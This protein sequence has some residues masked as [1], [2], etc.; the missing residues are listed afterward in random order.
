MISAN[1]IPTLP[2]PSGF[3]PG[4]CVVEDGL[5]ATPVTSLPITIQGSETNWSLQAFRSDDGEEALVLEAPERP[6]RSTAV[7]VVRV[8]SGC[9]TGD[10]FHSLRCDCQ[11]QLARSVEILAASPRG[12]L[13]YLP[14]HEGR[15][16]GLFRKVWAYALQDRGLDTIDANLAIGAPADGRSF[17]FAGRILRQR[18]LATIHLL[19][20][21]PAKADQLRQAGINVLREV[22]LRA[23]SHPQRERYILT[24]RR[25]FGHNV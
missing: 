3:L 9:V 11:A 23:D 21:N 19:T 18:G 5:A 4:A 2:D 15:G 12:V 7:P 8:H 17:A 14:A 24:K 25:R 6:D 1:S 22:P 13:V 20:N 16:I 10:V